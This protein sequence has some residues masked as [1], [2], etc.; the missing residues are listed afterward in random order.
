MAVCQVVSRLLWCHGRQ[1]EDTRSSGHRARYFQLRSAG[2]SE[3]SSCRSNA[4]CL[5]LFP[6]V[7]LV[8]RCCLGLAVLFLA[9]VIDVS[10]ATNTALN[11]CCGDGYEACCDADEG[12]D[13]FEAQLDAVGGFY[14]FMY[15]YGWLVAILGTVGLFISSCALLGCCQPAQT[16]T[17]DDGPVGAQ[18]VQSQPEAGSTMVPVSEAF[19]MPPDKAEPAGGGAI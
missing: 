19:P 1:E 11:T 10:G 17:D 6:A 9:Q 12:G 16:E 8:K 5:P 13:D 18:V 4:S 15:G 2:L 3:P 14:S 7:L